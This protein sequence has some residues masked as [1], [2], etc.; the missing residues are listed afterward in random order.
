MSLAIEKIT[1]L[2]PKTVAYLAERGIRSAQQL[3]DEGADILLQA[4][5]FY[6]GRARTVLANAAMLVA[7]DRRAI[8]TGKSVTAGAVK[9][10]KRK[11]AK[12]KNKKG[13]MRGQGKKKEKKI[14]KEKKKEKKKD[15]KKGKKKNKSKGKK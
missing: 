11:S 14:K 9:K 5:G 12:E 13:N 2:G 3:L 7:T 6:P 15:K 4:P 10:G 8:E 1:G